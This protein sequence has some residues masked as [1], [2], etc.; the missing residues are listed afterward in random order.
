MSDPK[1]I[2][3]LPTHRVENQPVP[4]ENYNLFEQDKALQESVQQ[5]AAVWSEEQ[6]H[7]FGQRLGSEE[8]LGWGEQANHHL[9]RLK[10]FDRYGRRIDEVEYHPAYHAL[11]ELAIS[12]RTHSIAWDPPRPGAQV[13]HAARLYLLSQVEAGV[14]CPVAMSY[15]AIPALKQDAGLLREW[16]PRLLSDQYDPRF[17]P[18][19]DKRGV[20]FGMAMTE[21][22]GGSDV[23]AN[24]TRARPLGD[25]GQYELEG[26]KW[27]CSAP[28]SDAFLSLAHTE[29]GLTCFVVPRWKPD[30]TRNPFFLQRLKDKLGNRSNASSEVEYAGTWAIR[31][32]EEGDGVRAIMP[33]VNH[34]RLDSAIAAASLMRQAFVQAAHHATHRSVFGKLLKD[35]P[36]MR[37]VLADLA[38]ESEAACHLVMR[39]ARLYDESEAFPEADMLSRMLTAVGKFWLNKR[40]PGQV[41]EALECLGGSGYVEESILPRLYRE[42]PLNGIWEGSGNVMCLDVRRILRLRPETADLFLKE[43]EPLAG[44]EPTFDEAVG[45]LK[46]SLSKNPGEASLRRLTEQLAVVY[47]AAVLMQAAPPEVAEAFCRSRLKPTH[48][49][50]GGLDPELPLMH[51]IRRNWPRID[52]GP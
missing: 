3:K 31:L 14:C 18:A 50:Y 17:I 35:Q 26:H 9:P 43:V 4:L 8:V 32:G 5:E 13:A 44:N 51:I 23:M 42:A 52:E 41:C 19:Q 40:A 2:S 27:F 37:N 39:L 29:A 28:M 48:G 21:K 20:T 33:M 38:L 7:A 16:G 34:T 11:L 46:D 22:Q 45:L 12:E 30:G 49:C 10:A 6:L 47:Q 24:S 1:P 15:A 25:A 36:L